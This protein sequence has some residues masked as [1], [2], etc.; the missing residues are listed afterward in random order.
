MEAAIIKFISC[1]LSE[2]EFQRYIKN[3]LLNN[4]LTQDML[5]EYINVF[6]P[7]IKIIFKIVSNKEYFN[8]DIIIQFDDIIIDNILNNYE[9]EISN[10]KI[11]VIFVCEELLKLNEH[12]NK[13]ENFIKSINYNDFIYKF[14]Y[15]NNSNIYSIIYN[16]N[17]TNTLTNQ[18]IRILIN[19]YKNLNDKDLYNY[20]NQIYNSKKFGFYFEFDCIIDIFIILNLDVSL[21]EHHLKRY[22][23]FN[24]IYRLLNENLLENEYFQELLY[25]IINKIKLS[26]YQLLLILEKIHFLNCN[27]LLNKILFNYYKFNKYKCNKKFF[28]KIK[29][30]NYDFKNYLFE[31]GLNVYNKESIYK[32]KLNFKN[33]NLQEI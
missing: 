29:Y 15:Q 19:N 30:G 23:I 13:I 3:G 28:E 9:Y 22:D 1:Q 20:I 33:S 7:F 2:N 16:S 12:K 25:Y 27:N 4:T 24:D 11:N 26:E 17:I 5:I 6:K 21:F 14:E 18:T 32:F 31:F 8:R 10:Y